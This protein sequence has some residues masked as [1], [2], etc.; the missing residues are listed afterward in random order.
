[1][2]AG[3]AMLAG[4]NPATAERIASERRVAAVSTAIV[5]GSRPWRAVHPE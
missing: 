5:T 3:L 4:D 1:M 2:R